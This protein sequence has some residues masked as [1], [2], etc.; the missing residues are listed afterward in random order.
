MT[1]SI[2]GISEMQK[3]GLKYVIYTFGRLVQS[4]DNAIMLPMT[5][6][7]TVHYGPCVHKD[8]SP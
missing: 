5:E 6:R 1:L 8:G 3:C 7:L 2:V 4:S